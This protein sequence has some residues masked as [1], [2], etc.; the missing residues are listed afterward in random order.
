MR[1]IQKLINLAES[2]ICSVSIRGGISRHTSQIFH[3]STFC[4]LASFFS[5]L[6]LIMCLLSAGAF[7][8]QSLSLPLWENKEGAAIVLSGALLAQRAFLRESA[9]ETQMRVIVPIAQGN[10]YIDD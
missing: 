3:L 9:A 1:P 7:R 4:L 2:V 8:K 10:K 5:L 6:R